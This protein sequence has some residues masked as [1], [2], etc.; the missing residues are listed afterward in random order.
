MTIFYERVMDMSILNDTKLTKFGTKIDNSKPISGK[1]VSE[2]TK[3]QSIHTDVLNNYDHIHKR[4]ELL[5]MIMA[6]SAEKGTYDTC[7]KA[8]QLIKD[9]YDYANSL[10]SEG[11]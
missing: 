3:I 2:P 8:N 10:F 9:C 6:S 7:E 4:A 5:M 11:K 1:V